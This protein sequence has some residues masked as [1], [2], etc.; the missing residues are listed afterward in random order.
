MKKIPVIIDC[1]PGLDDVV[2]LLMAG[3]N[4]K[5][6]LKAVTVVGGNQTLEKVGRNT[7]KVLS[8]ADIDVEEKI[9]EIFMKFLDSRSYYKELKKAGFGFGTLS[10]GE[11]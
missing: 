4:E 3:R 8:F 9:D 7:L 2:A 1:D 10:I 5:I 6:D 11:E